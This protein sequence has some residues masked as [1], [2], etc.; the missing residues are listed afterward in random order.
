[1]R[2]FY[3]LLGLIWVSSA[4]LTFALPVEARSF[5][6]P[7]YEVGIHISADSTVDVEETLTYSFIGEY[8]GVIRQITLDNQRTRQY[9]QTSGATCGG[10][11]RIV[12]LGIY[13]GKGNLIPRDSYELFEEQN[14]DSGNRYL[15][16]K[17]TVWPGGK[18]H[19]GEEFTWTIKYRL[20]GSLGWIGQSAE[21]AVPYLYWNVFPEDK[22]ANV[23]RAVTHIYLPPE[24]SPQKQN[25]EVYHGS[26][27]LNYSV[28]T[29]ESSLHIEA[30]GLDAYSP[31]TV[32]YALPASS[33][34][35]PSLLTFGGSLPIY[36]T[37]LSVDGVL[38]GNI[39]GRLNSMP[40]GEHEV[41]FSFPGYEDKIMKVD[42]EPGGSLELDSTLQPQAGISLAMT[43]SLL[44]NVAGVV[45]LPIGLLGVYRR[46]E[47]K[48]RD[49]KKRETIVPLYH[50]PADVRPYL[51]GSLYDERVNKRDVT[52]TII[53]LAYRG[54]IRIVEIDPRKN[55]KLE[56]RESPPN[57]SLNRFE[58][59]LIAK[60]FG[61]AD[62]VETKRLG[63]KFAPKYPKLEGMIYKEM[64]DRGYFFRSPQTT[65]WVYAGAGSGLL[66]L[67][68]FISLAFAIGSV[69]LLGF[70]G[71]VLLG[72]ALVITGL[73][74]LVTANF[75]PAKTELG[76]KIYVEVLGF[77]MYL[78]TAERYRLQ[79]LD[80][81]EFEKFLSYAVVFGIEKEWAEKFKD[82]YKGEP[83]WFV[84]SGSHL[85]DV[86]W[87]STM[88]RSFSD[89]MVT[90]AMN[91]PSSSGSGWSGGGGSFGGF[92]GG[93]GGGGGSG[94]F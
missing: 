10:F 47:H 79:G 11:E 76:S 46:W 60:L 5:T 67:G 84:G 6:Y 66:V 15:T 88:A 27:G 17:W 81:D 50:P 92:S 38:L 35:R 93:G 13:D 69:L 26:P 49:Q 29:G 51:L 63:A 71:P 86:Y 52:G 83:E 57:D 32:S 22:G 1:M 30:M 78:H 85:W 31:F 58:E 2:Y 68:V 90:T 16:V 61:N 18:I 77:R 25:L 48:G 9:C 53:D 54:F 3:K 43:I 55:Y 89:S 87:L 72:I 64:V 82:I 80:P 59:E 70:I 8:S 33:V 23:D 74:M 20:F 75:M 28:T 56:L 4:F 65:R 62:S 44:A 34:A 14:E 73:A 36:G 37:Q 91:P 24:V 41:G 45:L 39:D 42:I 7:S 21:S 94:A 19:N 12:I 40:S